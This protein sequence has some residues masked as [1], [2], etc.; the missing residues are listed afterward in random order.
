MDFGSSRT[1]RSPFRFDLIWRTFGTDELG[2]R[3]IFE[4]GD[5][6]ELQAEAH[7]GSEKTRVSATGHLVAQADNRRLNDTSGLP[8]GLKARA[9]TWAS[10]SAAV[11]RPLAGTLRMGIE[12]EWDQFS[13]SD[14]PGTNGNA[15]G[16]GPVLAMPVNSIGSVRLS[17]QVLAGSF[18]GDSHAER[19][20]L[21]GFYIS[22][23]LALRPQ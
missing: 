19:T 12:G 20:D 18:K 4:Q 7:W 16:F 3:K 13:G 1:G 22:L 6:A 15:Y 9:G 21:S 2:G 5:Q 11:D 17:T 8:E 10:L 23:Q 14:S